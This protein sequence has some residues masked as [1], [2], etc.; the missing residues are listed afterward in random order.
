ME[1]IIGLGSA[2]CN[3]A[4]CFA[5]Y[6]QYNIIKI[7]NGIYGAR[8]HFLPKYDTP[9]EYEAHIDSSSTFLGHVTGDVLFVVGG[10]GNVS[11]AALRILEQLR[12]C[13][14]SILYI[15]PDFNMLS[16]K[17]KLQERTTYYVF[18]EYARSAL[19][20]RLYLVSNP[21]LEGVLGEVPII[22][23]NDKLNQLIIT[24]FHMINV[25]NNNEPVIKNYSGFKEHTR[26]STIGVST[27]EN[28]KK[29]F[30]P[31]DSIREMRY[32]YAINKKKLETDGTLMRKIT[33]NV[34]KESE[35][36]VSYGVYATDYADDYVYCV[37]NAS[38][39]QYRENEKNTLQIDETVV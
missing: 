18:Q 39:I 5:Q 28:E 4:D 2:G 1:T 8:S 14:T 26:I 29:L 27:L 17:R 13:K 25:Y 19:F 6:P 37:A 11:G 10:S 12:H 7:D 24:T 22:G 23:Y 20:E 32:Y 30:F 35:Y 33:E 9:E 31:L 34:K 3:I 16:G 36:D 38:M 15:E 21:Q